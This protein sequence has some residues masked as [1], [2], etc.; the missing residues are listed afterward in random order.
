ML[1]NPTA[2]VRMKAQRDHLYT[3]TTLLEREL[4]IFRAQRLAKPPRQ[5]PHF[6]PELRAEILQLAA[7]RQW[8]VAHT[9]RRFGL[10]ENNIHSWKQALLN[11]RRADELLGAPHWYRL[12]QGVRRTVHE[13]RKMC[14]EKDSAR[15]PSRGRWSGRGSGSAG[16][17]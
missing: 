3:E 17:R 7:L 13:I 16:R 1:T 11:K 14:P 6:T 5:H 15:G 10:H 12:H 4:E 2:A 8:S 9:A